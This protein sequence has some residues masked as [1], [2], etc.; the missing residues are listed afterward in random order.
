[1]LHLILDATLLKK[2]DQPRIKLSVLLSPA[3]S[4]LPSFTS[5]TVLPATSLASRNSTAEAVAPLSSS[6]V[7]LIASRTS[8]Q[9]SSSAS[10][11]STSTQASASVSL[12]A[13]PSS[14]QSTPSALSAAGT[15][16]AGPSSS[17]DLISPTSASLGESSS[18]S[19]GANPCVKNNGGCE[20]KCVRHGSGYNCTCNTG[21][22]LRSDRHTCIDINECNSTSDGHKCAQICVNTVGS[23]ACACRKGYKLKNDG[24]GCEK[25]SKTLP[26]KMILGIV[27]GL[28]TLAILILV[29]R[30]ISRRVKRRSKVAGIHSHVMTPVKSTGAMAA[31]DQ[32]AIES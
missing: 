2:L 1:M 9:A 21:F 24:L 29:V 19:L 10:A 25:V 32:I 16:S 27:I 23:Y 12:T 11:S 31:T 8:I 30:V 28:V 15:T 26:I 18:S 13:S 7:S 17:A 4:L 6:F 5:T 22:K 14:N 3:S 20:Q